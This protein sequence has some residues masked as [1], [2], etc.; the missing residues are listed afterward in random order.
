MEQQ[1]LRRAYKRLMELNGRIECQLGNF[2]GNWERTL[3]DEQQ[4][5]IL[6]DF[7][8]VNINEGKNYQISKKHQRAKK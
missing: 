8:N 5:T 2:G 3:R 1:V 7:L 4:S 6:K